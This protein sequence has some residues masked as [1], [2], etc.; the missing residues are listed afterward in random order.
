MHANGTPLEPP[1]ATARPSLCRRSRPARSRPVGRDALLP[2]TLAVVALALGVAALGVATNRD[3]L[4]LLGI[5]ATGLLAAAL[6]V[7][8][9]RSTRRSDELR[10]ANRELQRTN[11]EL[12]ARRLAIGKALDLIDDRTNGWLYELVEV[13]GDELVE[14]VDR[15]VGDPGE[16]ER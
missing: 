13:M 16:D 5:A 11:A 6:A 1:R 3:A 9:S 7:S 2:A 4:A 15:Q 8:A 10:A 14:L 12:E